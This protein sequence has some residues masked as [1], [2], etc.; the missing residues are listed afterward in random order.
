[1]RCGTKSYATSYFLQAKKR[2]VPRRPNTRPIISPNR[3]P[4]WRFMIT[5]IIHIK[6]KGSELY[7][8]KDYS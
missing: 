5:P 4:I 3:R 7:V 2:Q 6:S 8:K 1:M